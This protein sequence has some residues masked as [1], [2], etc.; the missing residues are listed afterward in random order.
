MLP[1]NLFKG[2]T[3]PAAADQ[4]QFYANTGSSGRYEL[5]YLLDARPRVATHQWRAFLPGGG[6][7]GG[8][9]IAPG[10]GILFK[11]PSAAPSSR[12]VFRGQVRANPFVQPLQ[13]GLNLTASPFP[14]VA[15]PASIGL[16]DPLF[17]F[18]A[19]TKVEEADQFLL[20]QNNAF[21]VFYFLDHPTLADRWRE[22]VPSSPNYND[23][24]IFNPT[25]AIVFKRINASPGYRIPLRWSP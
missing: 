16:T 2:A 21:R 7:Q 5:F 17:A 13:A 12:L 10:E 6:D 3:D 15:S 11:R 9:V 25:E 24:L 4:L 1:K 19:S 20:Y 23:S 8:R 14:L 18:K 22:V